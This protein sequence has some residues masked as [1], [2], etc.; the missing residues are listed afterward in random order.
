MRYRDS[1]LR[2]GWMVLLPAALIVASGCEDPGASDDAAAA[3]RPV[4]DTVDPGE[5]SGALAAAN[6]FCHA[7]QTRD[8]ATGRALLTSRLVRKYPEDDLQTAIVGLSSPHHDAWEISGGERISDGR[9]AFKL[10]LFL[11]YTGERD[12]RHESP[13]ERIVMQRDDAGTWRVDEFPLLK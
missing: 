8:Y 6:H 10:R 11:A 2:S 7:W 4:E 9:I 1:L 12:R 13:V 3:D 5:Y